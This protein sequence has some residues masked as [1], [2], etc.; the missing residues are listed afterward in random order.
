MCMRYALSLAALPG[1]L[2]VAACGGSYTGFTQAKGGGSGGTPVSWAQLAAGLKQTCG[3]STSGVAYCWGTND[4]GEIGDGTTIAVRYTP[5]AVTGRLSFKSLAAGSGHSCGIAA[6]S[7][8]F[9][10]GSNVDAQLGD[11]TTTGHSA[12][13]AVI[14]GL[15]FAQLAAGAVYTCGI[16][17]SG[18]AYCW[19]D[20]SAGELGVGD[21]TRHG[22]P[23]RV[24][25]FMSLTFASLSA[26]DWSGSY[27]ACGI[28]PASVTYCWGDNA[29]G[30]L[31]TG[32]ITNHTLPVAVTGGVTFASVGAGGPHSCALTS[33]GAAY[34]WG[35]NAYG[36]LGTGDTTRRLTPTAVTGGLVFTSIA[37]G[38]AHTCALAS[39]AA[40]CWGYNAFGQL[41]VGDTLART[42]PT[43]VAGGLTFASLSAGYDHTCGI[44]TAGAAYCWGRNLEGQLGD[45]TTSNR[46][47]PVAVQNP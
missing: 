16:A 28:T 47:Q 30:E 12:P 5:Q 36:E 41:G 19:G 29:L 20:N 1:V 39:G 43:L 44:T 25:S 4:V 3:V 22:Q 14:G 33:A 17:T 24:G 46:L 31:G 2:A 45:N 32:D 40:Y 42:T 21:V 38:G 27:H 11:G 23:T 6:D 34:C 8:A 9:C 13:V 15:A 10:W 7:A 18:A 37:V 35:G 26:G